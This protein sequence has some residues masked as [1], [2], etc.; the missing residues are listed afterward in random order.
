MTKDPGLAIYID[1]ASRGNPGPAGVGVVIFG[2]EGETLMEEHLYI[3]EATNNVAEYRALLHALQKAREMG[4]TRIQVFT[5]SE[6][7]FRQMEGLY[8]VRNSKLVA[9]FQGAI[10]L[11]KDF[12]R[13]KL[14]HIRRSENKRADLLA[15]LAVDAGIRGKKSARTRRTD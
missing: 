8:R 7:L 12:Q 14:R 1:G 9:L 5:D 6:L 3:G 11:S 13:F 2:P 15:N 10:S 4:A